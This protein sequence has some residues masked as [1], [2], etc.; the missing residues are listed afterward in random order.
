MHLY[1]ETLQSNIQQSQREQSGTCTWVTAPLFSA[2]KTQTFVFC[3]MIESMLVC[4]SCQWTG[5]F[6]CSSKDYEDS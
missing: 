1:K 3:T 6:K 4:C 5:Y 2:E